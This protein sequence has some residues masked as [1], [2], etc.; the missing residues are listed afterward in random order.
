[1][2]IRE[3]GIVVGVLDATSLKL[4]SVESDRLK[5]MIDDWTERGMDILV[6]PE[7]LQEGQA[8]LDAFLHVEFTPDNLGMFENKL[9]RAGFEVQTD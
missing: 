4:T 5:E 9:L 8:S 3:D 2:I 7:R 6:P 1:M